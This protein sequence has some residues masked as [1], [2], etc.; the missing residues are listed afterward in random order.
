MIKIVTPLNG[1]LLF[2]LQAED[3]VYNDKE[4]SI[5]LIEIMKS[6]SPEWLEV[7]VGCITSLIMGCAM[8]VFAVLFGDVIGV[9][10][11]LTLNVL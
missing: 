11:L 6:N 2:E 7:T 8:P 9:R 5:S 1:M 10:H 3:D 4:Q